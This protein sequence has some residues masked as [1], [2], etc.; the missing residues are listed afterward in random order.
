MAGS[1]VN[2]IEGARIDL[3]EGAHWI[4]CPNEDTPADDYLALHEL[5]T[6]MG[7]RVISM[8]TNWAQSAVLWNIALDTRGG[9]DYYYLRNDHTHSSNRGL[10]TVDRR[11]GE[12]TRNADYYALGHFSK[13]V[14][15]GSHCITSE[16]RK[17]QRLHAAAFATPDSTVAAVLCNER[18]DPAILRIDVRGR[19]SQTLALPARSLTTV[20]FD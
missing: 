7:A 13:F 14:P 3:F 9:P 17:A 15:I 8:M 10:L 18:V 1:E 2:G 16:L 6:G 11:T 20:V 5:L 4:V 19:E 12:C